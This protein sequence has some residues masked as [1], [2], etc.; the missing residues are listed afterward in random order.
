MKL[1]PACEFLPSRLHDAAHSSLG[2]LCLPEVALGLKICCG[3]LAADCRLLAAVCGLRAALCTLLTA[4][5]GFSGRRGA[6]FMLLA[7]SWPTYYL[8]AAGS[9]L[10]AVGCWFL[11]AGGLLVLWLSS[12]FWLAACS[13]L[14]VLAAG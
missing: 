7:A 5:C 10:G 6:R 4:G 12:G 9:L 2:S 3:L 1:R 11:L 13:L 8:P 14:A